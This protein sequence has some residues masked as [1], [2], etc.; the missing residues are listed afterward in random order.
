MTG[1]EALVDQLFEV[2]RSTGDEWDALCPVHDDSSPSARINIHKGVWYCHSCHTGGK[3][4]RLAVDLGF[5]LPE[6]FQRWETLADLDE[7]DRL[8]DEPDE[9]PI[10][11]ESTLARYDHFTS[12]WS[13]RGLCNAAVRFWRLGFDPASQRATIPLR[14]AYG[15]LLG[16][17][18]RATRKGEQPKYVDPKHIRKTH[19]LFGGYEASEYGH[20]GLIALVEGPLDVIAM[21]E[22]G[23]AA[24]AP[25][26]S[27]FTKHQVRLLARLYPAEVCI[28][29]DNDLS[30][31]R[32]TAEVFELLRG[33]QTM[34][35]A[36][37]PPGQDPADL[38]VRQRVR[39]IERAR[40]LHWQPYRKLVP[41]RL[42]RE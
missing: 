41:D 31:R 13:D 28:A 9:D 18:K 6:D 11:P 30:G 20:D 25:L 4:S 23:I 14:N 27:T 34:T 5:D 32:A 26:G 21:W 33:K 8:L 2:K 37:I 15:E 40:D 17:S 38:T 12:Y 42:R 7:A 29:F 3:I 35:E 19:H 10:I 39:A 22:A 24:V 16:V 36:K 1:I